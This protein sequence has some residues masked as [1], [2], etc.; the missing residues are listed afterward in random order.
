MAASALTPTIPDGSTD[1]TTGFYA[2]RIST[3]FDWIGSVAGV[4]E[5]GTSGAVA[6]AGIAVLIGWFRARQQA[7]SAE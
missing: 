2:T 3:H 7:L 5:A 6:A 4:P 1:L